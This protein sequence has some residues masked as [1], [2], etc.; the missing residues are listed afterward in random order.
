VIKS[1]LEKKQAKRDVIKN[2]EQLSIED[3]VK[4]KNLKEEKRR[5]LSLIQETEKA[6]DFEENQKNFIQESKNNF[7]L[8]DILDLAKKLDQE[9]NEGV[10]SQEEARESNPSAMKNGET[11]IFTQ[12]EYML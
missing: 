6:L 7:S 4:Q 3:Q 5:L 11:I 9:G 8:Q 2:Q 1:I 12:D 10:A